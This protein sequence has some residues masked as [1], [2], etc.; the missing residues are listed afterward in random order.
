MK[1]LIPGI[2]ALVINRGSGIDDALGGVSKPDNDYR[3]LDVVQYARPLVRRAA[4]N[5]A[6]REHVPVKPGRAVGR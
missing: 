2:P 3:N 4:Q 6:V 5:G 1:T